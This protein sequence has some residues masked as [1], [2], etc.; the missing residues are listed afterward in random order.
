MKKCIIIL[1]AVW[2]Y[3]LFA[4]ASIADM[5][6]INIGGFVSQGFLQTS[7]NN[8]LADTHDGTSQFNEMGIYFKTSLPGNLRVGVQ[9]IDNY[10]L[11]LLEG[12]FIDNAG[13]GQ[14]RPFRAGD[15]QCSFGQA[16]TGVICFRAET[17]GGKGFGESV[18][19]GAADG[20]CA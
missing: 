15:D 18:Q 17:A 2:F 20:F 6:D 12:A 11:V 10:G 7:E 4:S 13:F 14:L 19:G 5:G 8:Y 16:I 1:S 3:V 9:F